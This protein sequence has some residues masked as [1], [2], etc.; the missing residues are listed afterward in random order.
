MDSKEEEIAGELLD[1]LRSIAKEEA[2]L[3][4]GE[5]LARLINVSK[6]VLRRTTYLLIA[7]GD[8]EIERRGISVRRIRVGNHWTG[9]NNGNRP[10]KANKKGH[11]QCND[12][13]QITQIKIRRCLWSDCRKEFTPTYHGEWYCTTCRRSR[14]DHESLR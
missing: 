8:I 5:E 1:M 6:A 2:V 12:K 13:G 14:R 3:P 4:Q 7:R 9:W 10:C 11:E